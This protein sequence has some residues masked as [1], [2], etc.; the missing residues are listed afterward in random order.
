MVQ[1]AGCKVRRDSV[2]MV[3]TLITASPEFMKPLTAG[4]NRKPI[5]QGR[6]ILS[7][8]VVGEK[9]SSLPSVHMDEKTPDMHLCFVPV[10]PEGSWLRQN[11]F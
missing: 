3:E 9:G 7:R 4:G 1:E 8:N 2:M 10:T 6:W 11:T 5:F